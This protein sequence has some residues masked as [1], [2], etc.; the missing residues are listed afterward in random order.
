M[1]YKGERLTNYLEKYAGKEDK[2]FLAL[3]KKYGPEPEDPYYASSSS[4]EE[5]DDEEEETTQVD[6]EP[7]SLGDDVEDDASLGDLM[8][9]LGLGD[10]EDEFGADVTVLVD[11]DDLGRRPR[12]E[13]PDGDSA[14]APGPEPAQGR[15]GAEGPLSVRDRAPGPRRGGPARRRGRQRCGCR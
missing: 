15:G 5:E 12:E 1:Y 9:D 4:E 8:G 3:V 6:G 14:D 10:F 7:V 11:D 2:L 13:L